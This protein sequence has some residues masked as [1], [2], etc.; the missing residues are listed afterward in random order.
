MMAS[1][2]DPRIKSG[3]G[4]SD[5]DKEIIY[6][7]IRES[8]IEIEAVEIGHVHPHEHQQSEQVPAPHE[9]IQQ[10]PAEKEDI[11]DELNSHYID[12]NVHWVASD[13]AENPD[14]NANAATIA[15][16]EITLHKK[17]PTLK[18]KNEDGSCKYTEQNYKLG[19]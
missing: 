7:N 11:F 17:E 10:Q 16:A 3:V 8:T 9:Q 12:E 18:L 13:G 6:D 2:S 15:D 14:V 1:F 19:S 4:I 5:A